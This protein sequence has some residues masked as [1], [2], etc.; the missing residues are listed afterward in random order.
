MARAV[1]IS[2]ESLVA[3]PVDRVQGQVGLVV[4]DAEGTHQLK[5]RPRVET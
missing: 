4:G 1:A 3:L 5:V 2:Y